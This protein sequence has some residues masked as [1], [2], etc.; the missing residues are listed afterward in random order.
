M[1]FYRLGGGVGPYEDR[2]VYAGKGEFIFTVQADRE[3]TDE[4]ALN[5]I[6]QAISDK[7][8]EQGAHLIKWDAYVDRAPAQH[9]YKGV[10]IATTSE[11]LGLSLSGKPLS[12]DLIAAIGAAIVAIGTAI[13]PYIG[14]IIAAVCIGLVLYG[15]AYVLERIATVLY[16]DHGIVPGS[17]NPVPISSGRPGA[18]TS[19]INAIPWIIGGS[20]VLLLV[21]SLMPEIKKGVATHI[22]KHERKNQT[23]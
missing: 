18:L 2:N 15:I 17:E 16:A 22:A 5:V 4:E 13:A 8:A 19:A 14:V 6:Y 7:V 3:L 21:Y 23:T 9:V 1:V 10:F 20:I 11:A 12:L